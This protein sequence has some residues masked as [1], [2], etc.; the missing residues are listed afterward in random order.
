MK[1]PKLKVIA[2][3]VLLVTIVVRLALQRLKESAALVIIAQLDL[4]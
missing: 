1:V 3:S 2:S 4:Q